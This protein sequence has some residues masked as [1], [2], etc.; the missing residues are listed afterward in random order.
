MLLPHVDCMGFCY[1]FPAA[2]LREFDLKACQCMRFLGPIDFLRFS[3]DVFHSVTALEHQSRGGR[4][5]SWVKGSVCF[6]EPAEG[7]HSV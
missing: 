5:Q 2:S 1:L 3:L 7:Q 4:W 6:P